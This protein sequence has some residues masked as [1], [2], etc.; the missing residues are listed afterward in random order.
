MG[1]SKVVPFISPTRVEWSIGP[2]NSSFMDPIS[3]VS[4]PFGP[5]QCAEGPKQFYKSLMQEAYYVAQPNLK[6]ME[7]L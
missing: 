2:S 6:R 3:Q 7:R 5:A 1:H 4:T